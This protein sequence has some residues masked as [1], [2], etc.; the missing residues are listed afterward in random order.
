[1]PKNIRHNKKYSFLSTQNNYKPI[2][3]LESTYLN[4]LSKNNI[5]YINN[6]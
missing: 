3:L 5:N 2:R 1:M 6:I 4:Y